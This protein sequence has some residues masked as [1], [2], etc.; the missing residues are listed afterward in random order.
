MNSSIQCLAHTSPLRT[1]FLSGE[2]ARDLNKDNPLGTGG[3]LATQFANLMGDMW[4]VATKRRSLHGVASANSSSGAVYPR[5]FKHCLGKHA[6]QFI[7]YDQH[8]SQEVATYLLD[9]LHEDTNRVT[10]KPYVEIPEQGEDESDDVAADKAW[11]LHQKREDS[12]VLEN[13]MGQIKSR[14]ECCK[15][16]CNRVS[17][18][19]D[20]FMFLSVPIPGSNDRTLSVTFVP[21]DPTKRMR[22]MSLTVSK[23]AL[24]SGLLKKMN[25]ELVEKGVISEPIP[26]EDLAAADVWNHEIFGWLQQSTDVDR[27]R[28]NDNTF[29]YQLQT[30]AEVQEQSKEVEEMKIIPVDVFGRAK[31]KRRYTLDID[32]MTM[33][34]RED[35]WQKSLEKYVQSPMMLLSLFNPKRGSNEERINFYKKLETFIDLCLKEIEEEESTGTKRPRDGQAKATDGDVPNME[36]PLQ[37]LLD[38]CD[39]FPSFKGVRS[40]Q[41]VAILEVCVNQLRAYT[42]KLLKVKKVSYKDGVLV[43]VIMRNPKPGSKSDQFVHPLVLRIPARMTV[44]AFREYLASNLSRSI[45]TDGSQSAGSAEPSS[46]SSGRHSEEPLFGSTA[47]VALRQVALSYDRKSGHGTRPST[48]TTYQMGMISRSDETSENRSQTSIAIHTDEAEKELVAETVGPNGSIYVDLP[49]ERRGWFFDASEFDRTEPLVPPAS[50]TQP[51]DKGE[52]VITVMDCIEKYCQ[53][54]QLEETEMWYC[55]RCQDHVR[56]WKQFHIYRTPPILIIHLKRFH[57]SASTHRRNKITSLID[58]PL[59]GLDLTHLASHY[60]EGQTPIYDCY[61][62]SNHYGSLGGGHYTAYT[63]DDNGTWLHYDDSVVSEATKVITEAAYVLYYRRRDVKVG[64]DLIVDDQTAHIVV[65]RISPVTS[66]AIE[67]P[68]PDNPQGIEDDNDDDNM[69]VDGDGSSRTSPSPISDL[70]SVDG[71]N[72]ESNEINMVS[73][74]PESG[75]SYADFPPLQ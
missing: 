23:S 12:R 28:D 72:E 69:A 61:A 31:R 64:E 21:L 1:Y 34:N 62:V 10:Q 36:E 13:F 9:K 49:Q 26:R 51:D 53:K 73:F 20:P 24:V 11:K 56:A 70:G 58:F 33:L 50:G 16:G 71:G 30:L 66:I 4:G 46:L 63:L 22:S 7:G 8:D 65:D 57:Y 25:E 29:V 2:Y 44:F 35:D 41:D 75:L 32:T 68:S 19:Y 55:N 60:E 43:Q 5:S 3:E 14:L 45:G 39:A 40:R 47:V 42:L 37:G 74:A 6:E 18:T 48:T 52:K 15:E 17:T 38:R 27:I 67:E 54:E 59:Q